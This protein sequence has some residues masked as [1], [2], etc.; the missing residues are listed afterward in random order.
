LRGGQVRCE[1]RILVAFGGE[2][3]LVKTDILCERVHP[4]E[5]ASS[6]VLFLQL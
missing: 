2:E 5:V 6:S 1:Q 3:L 4:F